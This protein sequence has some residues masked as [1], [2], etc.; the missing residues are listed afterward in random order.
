MSTVKKFMEIIVK[1]VISSLQIWDIKKRMDSCILDK[2]PK[3]FLIIK[4]RVKVLDIM[5]MVKEII[6]DNGKMVNLMVKAQL[7]VLTGVK[8]TKDN[9]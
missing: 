4:I 7:S 1:T 5:L 6:S 2:E 8:N 3:T 9:S